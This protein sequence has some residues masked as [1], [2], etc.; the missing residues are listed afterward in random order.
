MK[1][2]VAHCPVTEVAVIVPVSDAVVIPADGATAAIL[3]PACGGA[4]CVHLRDPRTV[5]RAS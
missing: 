4:H 5:R 1:R 3:C 2:F